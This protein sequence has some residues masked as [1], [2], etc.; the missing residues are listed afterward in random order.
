MFNENNDTQPALIRIVDNTDKIVGFALTGNPQKKT[1]TKLSNAEQLSGF[2][3]YMLTPS[4]AKPFALIG[5]Q[6]SCKM[7][8]SA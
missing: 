3:G 6:H 2:E 4:T 8:V 5:D 1:A 7:T